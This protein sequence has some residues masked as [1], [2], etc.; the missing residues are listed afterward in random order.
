MQSA[1]VSRPR[2]PWFP[3][4]VLAGL[5]AFL[6][7]CG[8]AGAPTVDEAAPRPSFDAAQAADAVEAA[9]SAEGARGDAQ[10]RQDLQECLAAA[11]WQ[12]DV[13]PGSE[14]FGLAVADLINSGPDAAAAVVDCQ[15][16]KGGPPDVPEAVL[17]EA[18]ARNEATFT[19]CMT[20][21]GFHPQP[22][23]SAEFSD[24]GFAHTYPGV[25][26]TR[27]DFDEVVTACGN[28]GGAAQADVITAYE[29]AN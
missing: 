17:A 29:A 12:L 16:G 14:T 2:G 24:H 10:L 23:T 22:D 26:S 15:A 5:T 7:G 18:A 9:R 11:G 6:A 13:E 28:A 25:E 4:V 3:S 21:A 1:S 19:D 8:A 27:A 20:E